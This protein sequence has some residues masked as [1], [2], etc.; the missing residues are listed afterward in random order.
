MV[1]DCFSEIWDDEKQETWAL[2]IFAPSQNNIFQ[3][4]EIPSRM[5]QHIS[6]SFSHREAQQIFP[7]DVK[8]IN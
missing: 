2:S 8:L 4:H 7:T 5:I 6:K 3:L 1:W